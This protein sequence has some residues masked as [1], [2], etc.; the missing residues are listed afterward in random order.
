ME[1]ILS[2][3]IAGATKMK[4]ARGPQRDQVKKVQRVRS[5]ETTA[6]VEMTQLGSEMLTLTGSSDRNVTEAYDGETGGRE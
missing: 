2:V 5:P 6:E 4:V 3:E 1:R